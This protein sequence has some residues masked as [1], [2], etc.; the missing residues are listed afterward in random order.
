MWRIGTD[1]ELREL[2]KDVD[3]VAGI[4]M[5]RLE[6]I[7]HVVRMVQGKTVKKISVTKPERSG[8]RG[9]PGLR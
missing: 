2:C 3:I 6:W 1:W 7:R 5:K 9:T 4:K 8:R